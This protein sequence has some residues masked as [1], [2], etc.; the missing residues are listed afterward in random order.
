MTDT[1]RRKMFA[2]ARERELDGDALRS[3]VGSLVGKSSLRELTVKDAIKVIDALLGKQEA[4]TPNGVRMISHKQRK[5]I[6]SMAVELGWVLD[7]GTL[8]TRR[9]CRWLENKYGYSHISW[10]TSK[11]AS[12]AIEGLKKMK[13]RAATASAP[14]DQQ[15]AAEAAL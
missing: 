5:F 15:I 12:D 7:D 10:L 2:L 9:L 8:D 11:V 13:Q 4:I 1:Q 14:H 3:C 6:E